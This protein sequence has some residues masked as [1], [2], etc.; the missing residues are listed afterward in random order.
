LHASG[1]LALVDILDEQVNVITGGN[2]IQNRQ[3]VPF[4]CL[5][6]PVSPAQSVMLKLEQELPVMASVRE[7][8]NSVGRV[9]AIGSRHDRTQ[10][11]APG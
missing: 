11:I 2:V 10:L 7:V 3:T 6:Q 9:K 4:S 5:V 8:P 1:N